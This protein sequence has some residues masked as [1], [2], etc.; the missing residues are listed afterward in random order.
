M[1]QDLPA[2]GSRQHQQGE[3]AVSED[4]ADR[5]CQRRRDECYAKIKAVRDETVAV[6]TNEFGPPT[7]PMCKEWPHCLCVK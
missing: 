3:S 5:E 7:E 4:H 1:A 6:V 2:V